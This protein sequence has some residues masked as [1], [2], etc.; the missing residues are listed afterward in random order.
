[1]PDVELEGRRLMT[2]KP[3]ASGRNSSSTWWATEGQME[4]MAPAT[5]AV[6]G[7]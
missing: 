7:R 3:G 5:R 4:A 2:K 1:M 6:T